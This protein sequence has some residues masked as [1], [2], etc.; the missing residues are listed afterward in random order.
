MTASRRGHELRGAPG[1]RAPPSRP[2]TREYDMKR[3]PGRFAW[4]RQPA[5]LVLAD[6]VAR[7]I[8]APA[9]LPI[10]IV[11]AVLGGPFFLVL[12]VRRRFTDWD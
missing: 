8:V 3:I 4:T 6:C 2:G 12:L 9:E 1:R 7:T 10:G 11:T 5:L